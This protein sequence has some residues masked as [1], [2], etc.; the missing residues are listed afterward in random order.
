M[1]EFASMGIPTNQSLQTK[2]ADAQKFIAQGGTLAGYIDKMRKDYMNKDEYK[3][4]SEFN[5]RK[6]APEQS[7]F[8]F[9]NIGDGRIAIQDPNT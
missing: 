8:S 7:Q 1:D 2:V 3:A 5:K 4:L 9:A 6:L